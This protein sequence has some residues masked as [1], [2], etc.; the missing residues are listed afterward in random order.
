MSLQERLLHYK[1]AIPQIRLN[2]KGR[3]AELVNPLIRLFSNSPTASKKIIDSLS[4]FMQERN[5]R[6]KDSF[7]AKLRESIQSLIDM[8]LNRINS[9]G[10]LDAT[11]EEDRTLG[12]YTFTN[13]SIKN[14]L[15]TDSDAKEDPE[16]KGSYYSP[17]LGI[18]FNQSKITT[19]LKSKFKAK[20]PITKRIG[21]KSYR[22][23]EF[24]Q[25]YLNRLKASYTVEKEI[26]I[27]NGENVTPVTPVT[28]PGHIAD[29]NDLKNEEQSSPNEREDSKDVVTNQGK[30]GGRILPQTITAVTTVTCD[31]CGDNLDL[32]PFYVKIHLERCDGTT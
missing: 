29:Q 6:M 10:T 25:E 12:V 13:E 27:L 7:E 32:D 19:I 9:T 26:K 15:I 5:E 24:N 2:V 23:V 20:L 3:T 31:K 21:N 1:D 8:R 28:P 18:G 11:T 22:C 4:T 16:K 14:Q 17:G 30:K